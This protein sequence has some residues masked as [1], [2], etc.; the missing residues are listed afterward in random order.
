MSPETRPSPVN[1][2]ASHVRIAQ[3][4]ERY[5]A[6]VHDDTYF[7]FPVAGILEGEA[8]LRSAAN[9]PIA[10][11]SME[12]GLATN[13]YNV[14]ESARPV[15]ADNRISENEIISNDRL[16][17]YLFSLQNSEGT[18]LDLP[19]YSGGLGVLAG[20]TV[21]TAA[22][23]RLPFV[24]VG[25]LWSKGYFRQRFWFKYGQLPD[26][27]RWDPWTFPG[28]VPLEDKVTVDLKDRAVVLR[29]WKYYVYS[30]RRDYAV[31]LV[32]LDSDVE[33][34]DAAAR[35]DTD[36]LYRSDGVQGR[37]IQRVLLGMG[38]VKALEALGYPVRLHH[39]NEGHAA[40]A[41][42]AKA[43]QA[44]SGAEQALREKFV[45]TCHT[46]V[47][48]GH[49]RFAFAEVDKI[50]LPQDAAI[51]RR[52]G[53]EGE[54]S[55]VLNLTLL[56]MNTSRAVN[57]VSRKHG[58][59][60]RLQFP[61]Y[62]E[63]IQTVTNGIHFPTWVSEPVLR[64]LERFHAALGDVRQDPASLG[65]V[66]GLKADK[67]LRA[68]FWEAHQENKQRLATLLKDW[69]LRADVLTLAWA[70]RIAAYKR[71]SLLFYDLER[72]K[73]LSRR[74]GPLQVL[75]AGKAHPNDNMA[76]TYINDIMNAIDRAQD[77]EGNLKII[78]LE[79]YETSIARVLVACVDVWLNNPL[80]PYEA[81]GTSGMKALAN[82]VVQLSTRD[83][84]VIEAMDKGIGRFFGYQDEGKRFT[85]QMNLHIEDDA[86]ALY[87]A[88]EE[89]MEVYYHGQKSAQ[90]YPEAWMDMMIECLVEAG[91][92]NTHRMVAEYHQKIWNK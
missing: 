31:P 44:G 2:L 19:I 20:D 92:F 5:A 70:R 37:L 73:E 82:G 55:E 15:S 17:D 30:S 61:S 89:L 72:L 62:A 1:P 77:K 63:R 76:F 68:A 14:F 65:R 56:A 16:R 78:M 36:Q 8:A 43:R 47:L 41:F 67:D 22:D 39:L 64:V 27:M 45:Y 46:P 66:A 80:P 83:G 11:F 25:I 3:Y 42:V 48:A 91:T 81:S 58:E 53:A 7:G 24:A 28:L 35:A 52:Y 13:S 54:R 51:A 84:W 32:L 74:V 34:N 18:L 71:P 12:H 29:L 10:Y 26:E 86:A 50:L 23:M 4:A 21:K 49:D 38:G 57:A 9:R 90:G 88:L 75:Y 40:F 87:A 33:E 59:V 69:R 60:M 79:N 85:D 6:D